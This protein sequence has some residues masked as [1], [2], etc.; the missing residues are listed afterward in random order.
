MTTAVTTFGNA[1]LPSVSTLSAALKKNV[2]NIAP[3]GMVI[4]KFDKTGAWVF[5]QNSDETEE[6]SQWA[7]NPYSFCHGLIAWG[8]GQ[9]VGEHMVPMTDDIPTPGPLPV[10]VDDKGWQNQVGLSLKCLTGQ[11]AG[12]EV[13]YTTTSVGGKRA[14]QALGIALAEQIDADQTKPVAIVTLETDSYKHSSYGKVFTP[15]FEI[16]GF[17][18]LDAPEAAPPPS[19]KAEKVKAD[20]TPTRRRRS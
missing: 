18:G 14:V 12:M 6:G 3:S 15:I 11:D 5:G 13:R 10:G 20:A 9:P 8:D 1:K 2:A 19:P 7:V 16:V 17:S 4:L